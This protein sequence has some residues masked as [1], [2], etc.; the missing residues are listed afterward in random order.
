MIFLILF[1][2]YSLSFC[3]NSQHFN[4]NYNNCI[5]SSKYFKF[6]KNIHNLT[7]SQ[8]ILINKDNLPLEKTALFIIDMQMQ[9]LD[10]LF[11]GY[12][13]NTENLAKTIQKIR[14]FFKKK[15]GEEN[16][17]EIF[18]IDC[19]MKYSNCQLTNDEIRIHPDLINQEEFLKLNRFP[20]HPI[21][22]G[23]EE[24]RIKVIP[25]VKTDHIFILEKAFEQAEYSAF[26]I[27]PEGLNKY[28][29]G[30]KNSIANRILEEREIKNV[31]VVGLAFQKC[32]LFTAADAAF[33]K[34]KTYIVENATNS[35]VYLNE[36][37]ELFFKFNEN[38]I[39]E[40]Q[41]F[42]NE[43]VE[44]IINNKLNGLP[45]AEDEILKIVIFDG[46]GFIEKKLS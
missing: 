7:N 43:R 21:I 38:Y 36:I 5:F 16:Y 37:E 24:D 17:I 14:E 46:N 35:A 13:P 44:V 39:R 9:Y 12:V 4:K 20:I 25:N 31:Y 40:E 28:G 3:L 1:I 41:N 42:E 8:A 19:L 33:L 27:N 10:P 23:D 6:H 34:Y 15:L 32:V 45:K 11:P 2:S 29:R 18:T 26:G 30:K 22:E